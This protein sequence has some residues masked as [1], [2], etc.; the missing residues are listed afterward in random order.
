MLNVTQIKITWIQNYNILV[1]YLISFYVYYVI[2]NYKVM[3]FYLVEQKQKMFLL[4][5]YTKFDKKTCI[6]VSFKREMI[7]NLKNNFLNLL[8]NWSDI[9]KNK[10]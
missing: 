5:I 9:F 1:C 3:F 8:I 6:G 2:F 7:I 10:V 4:S